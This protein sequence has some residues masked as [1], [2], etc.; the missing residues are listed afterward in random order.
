MNEKEIGEIRR[1]FKADRNNIGHIRGCYVNE[2]HETI[3]LFDESLKLMGA[4]DAERYLTIFRRTL[5][6]GLG[7][8]MVDISFSTAQVADSDEHRLLMALKQSALK[9]EQAVQ[10][11]FAKVRE[12]LTLEGQYVI[13]LACD[14]YDVP[15]KGSDE[16]DQ[17]DNSDE[18]YS[19]ILCSICPVKQT[20]PALSYSFK[21]NEFRNRA[22][23]WVVSS[24]ELG[25]LFPAFDD[26]STNLYNALYYSRDLKENHPEFV[27]SVF[28][29]DV[30]MP[31][32]EQ[33]ETFQS[34][35]ANT[36]G[37]D[38]SYDL[39]QEMHERLREKIDLH[40]ENKEVEPL[41]VSRKEMRNILEDCGV[42]EEKLEEFENRFDYE[43]GESAE[44]SP[45]NLVDT[46]KFELRTPDVIIKVT[47][48][49]SDL[50]QTRIINGLKYIV[51][52]ATEGV[53]V[54]GVNI[55]IREEE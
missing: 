1:R 50:I 46:K 13:L 41:T 29:T 47:P 4:E 43:F 2:K 55:T 26:R 14:T 45:K 15:F 51:I 32:A 12:A 37:V 49:R 17:H 48:E 36:L 53:E 21:E 8:N 23:D 25:F 39:V 19:Y 3:S 16:Q 27:Q 11:F 52:D 40:K 31:A 24:P 44:V 42:K 20:K 54:N 10:E 34:V 5:S 7:K 28:C 22:S 35:L 18:V 33:K 9:D 6:G 30:P 38:C